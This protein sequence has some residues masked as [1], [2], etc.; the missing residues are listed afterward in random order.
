MCFYLF[1]ADCGWST[2]ELCRIALLLECASISGQFFSKYVDRTKRTV[3]MA[4]EVSRYDA[5]GFQ[6]LEP[7]KEFNI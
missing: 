1:A 6:S 5:F 4:C 3:V 7:H 2:T